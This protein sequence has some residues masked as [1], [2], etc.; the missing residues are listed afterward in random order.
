MFAF[1]NSID[2]SPMD[3]N[4]VQHPPVIKVPNA[5]QKAAQERLETRIA[6]LKQQLDRGR[7]GGGLR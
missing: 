6:A 1:F 5:E 7:Q 3:G 4:A 2:G